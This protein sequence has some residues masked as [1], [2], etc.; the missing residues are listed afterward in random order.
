MRRPFRTIAVAV[1][2]AGLTG[3]LLVGASPAQAA[4][5]STPL[6]STP[7]DYSRT[8]G[9]ILA[10]TKVATNRIAI[11]GNFTTV[12]TADGV[13]HAA[14]YFA[15]LNESTGALVYAGTFNSY[16]RAISAYDGTTY[17]GGDFTTVGTTTRNRAA[18]F[19]STWTLTSWNPAPSS[20][21]RGVAS[22][23]TGVYIGGDGN[24]VRKV[25][26]T[27]GATVWS[28][29]TTLGNVHAVYASSGYVFIGGQFETYDG[30][31]QH[32]LV[33]VTPSTGAVVTAFNAHLRVDSGVGDYGDYDGEAA[34]SF[35]TYSSTR[36]VV[37]FAGHGSDEV[38][39]L[40]FTTGALVW[41]KVLVADGQ[42]VGVVGTTIVVGYHRNHDNTTINYPYFAAQLEASN[43][44][45]TDWDP[46]VTG[47]GANADGGNNGVQAVY[48][49][50]TTRQVFVAG[51]FT[52]WNGT[53]THQSLVVFTW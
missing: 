1:A 47:I 9:D 24:V 38:K 40:N 43:A 46:K 33:K 44:A 15:V 12:Y 4:V 32:G 36:L 16:V 35:A 23:S 19:S 2:V 31:T 18:A 10:V 28:K 49:D 50:P 3:G 45:L 29:R 34:I 42:G 48:A 7:L 37:G 14:K 20:R 39:M 11:G 6:S 21:L 51:A 17:V 25:S 27:T 30:V 53:A 13:A 41:V 22:D 5:G 8:N 26:L 52:K